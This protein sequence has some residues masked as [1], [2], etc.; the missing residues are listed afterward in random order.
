MPGIVGPDGRPITGANALPSN[1]QV[2][3]WRKEVEEA[4]DRPDVQLFAQA[5]VV[6]HQLANWGRF[7]IGKL[8][9]LSVPARNAI[10]NL[11]V[12]K[13]YNPNTGQPQAYTAEHMLLTLEEILP[14]VREEVEKRGAEAKAQEDAAAESEVE[15]EAKANE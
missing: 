4:M 13:I 6:G 14:Q 3:Q 9:D 12:T 1:E 5:M 2:E 11:L 10:V 7:Y 8:D 15:E